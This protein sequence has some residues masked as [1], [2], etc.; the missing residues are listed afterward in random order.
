MGTRNIITGAKANI[1]SIWLGKACEACC[2]A[3]CPVL[4]V[5]DIY[6]STEVCFSHITRRQKNNVFQANTVGPKEIVDLGPQTSWSFILG[7]RLCV[8]ICVCVFV[9]GM[10]VLWY[11]YVSVQ[12]CVTLHTHKARMCNVFPSHPT[13][14]PWGRVS[15]RTRRSLFQ[16]E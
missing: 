7:L 9:L 14:L 3:P 16:I 11:K 6:F 4:S 5:L 13:V 12:V 15:Q 8:R 10:H 1:Y 2:Y